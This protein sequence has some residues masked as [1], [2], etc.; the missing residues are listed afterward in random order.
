MKQR[1]H[2]ELILIRVLEFIILISQLRCHDCQF[3]ATQIIVSIKLRERGI[4]KTVEI[5]DWESDK[6]VVAYNSKDPNNEFIAGN[7]PI[8][9]KTL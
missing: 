9:T 4:K 7:K 8:L 3:L 5:V 2:I 6:A 1:R